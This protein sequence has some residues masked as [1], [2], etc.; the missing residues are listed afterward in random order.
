MGWPMKARRSLFPDWPWLCDESSPHITALHIPVQILAGKFKMEFLLTVSLSKAFPV[1]QARRGRRAPTKRFLPV[2]Q[3][4][5]Q[6]MLM[7]F[8]SLSFFVTF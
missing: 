3:R 6:V 1:R 4:R 7:V 8:Q 5:G 2:A